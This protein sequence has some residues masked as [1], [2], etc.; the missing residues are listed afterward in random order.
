MHAELLDSICFSLLEDPIGFFGS[1]DRVIF[2]PYDMPKSVSDEVTN[3][4]KPASV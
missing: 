4:E 1:I 3:G 2:Y